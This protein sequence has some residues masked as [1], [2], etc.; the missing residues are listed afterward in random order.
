M[1]QPSEYDGRGHDPP[2][3]TLADDNVML[4]EDNQKLRQEIERLRAAL[5]AVATDSPNQFQTMTMLR[6]IARQALAQTAGGKDE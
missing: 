3:P 4:V 1:M 2:Y 6:T 5:H